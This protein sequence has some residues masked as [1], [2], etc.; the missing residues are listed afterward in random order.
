M[1]ELYKSIVKNEKFSKYVTVDEN[2]GYYLID[3]NSLAG[4]PDSFGEFVKIVKEMSIYAKVAESIQQTVTT[5]SNSQLLS[6]L[7][8]LND[9]INRVQNTLRQAISPTLEKIK[10]KI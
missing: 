5:F 4:D 6:N 1:T 7:N 3:W 10:I 9:V 2:D 8:R